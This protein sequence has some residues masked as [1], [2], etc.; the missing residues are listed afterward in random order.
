[1]SRPHKESSKMEARRIEELDRKENELSDKLIPSNGNCETLGG[2]LLRAVERLIYRY[3]NDG[4]VIGMGYGIETCQSSYFYLE[5]KLMELG[6]VTIVETPRCHIQ[7]SKPECDIDEA[8]MNELN[9]DYSENDR[10]YDALYNL[11]ALV[12]DF[13]ENDERAK[14]PN[15]E[16]S[17]NWR[18]DDVNDM[19]RE[20]EYEDDNY[21]EEKDEE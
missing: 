5:D 18:I 12:I 4:D 9:F 3:C 6:V 19:I 10:Y 16:D 1:M 2:E 7:W 15:D 11:L 20:S 17:R 13:I 21:D 14:L 8:A